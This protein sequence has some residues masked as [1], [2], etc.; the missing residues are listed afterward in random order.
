MSQIGGS[1]IFGDLSVDPEAKHILQSITKW[2]RLSAIVGLVSALLSL[3]S[4]VNGIIKYTAS[5]D[6]VTNLVMR[7][8]LLF[9]IPFAVG[10][11]VTNIFLLRF[12]LSTGAGLQNLSQTAFNMGINFLK[13]YFKTLGIIII[14]ALGLVL[15]MIIAFA[16]GA[17][18][19][20]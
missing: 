16:L 12:A 10:L 6:E 20:A 14:I 17:A 13:M 11:I 7:I 9:I 5:G 19:G 4:S 8:S 1:D 2:A 3:V 15:V 18:A